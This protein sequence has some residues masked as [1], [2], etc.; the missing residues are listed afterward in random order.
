MANNLKND[1]IIDK[2]AKNIPYDQ[3]T[4]YRTIK[5]VSVM[6]WRPVSKTW[7]S[8]IFVNQG[9]KI[10]TKCYFETIL[11]PMLESAKDHFS[12][13]TL[14]DILTRWCNITQQMSVKPGAMSIFHNFGPKKCGLAAP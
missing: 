12:E 4:V 6:F 9:V 13:N 11:K 1:G 8:L 7:R 2:S 5:P 10:Y 3:K 14:W